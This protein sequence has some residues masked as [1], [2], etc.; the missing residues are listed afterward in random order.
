M[1]HLGQ[2]LAADIRVSAADPSQLDREIGHN[3]AL[4][5]SEVASLRQIE[6]ATD[7]YDSNYLALEWRRSVSGEHIKFA[8]WLTST[9]DVSSRY[10]Y[11]LCSIPLQNLGY[12][13]QPL[14][15]NFMRS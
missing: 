3:A 15:L 5:G 2:A 9:K 14:I 7:L 12:D 4:C 13:P 11:L 10:Y 8:T 1:L 6:T